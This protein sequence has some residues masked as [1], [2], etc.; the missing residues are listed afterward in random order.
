M[1]GFQ[2]GETY[3]QIKEYVQEHIGLKVSSLYISQ[4]KRNV[5]W[6]LDKTITY[7]RK[8]TPSSHNA[9]LKR[10]KQPWRHCNASE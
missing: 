6:M 4:V 10:K 1:S 8:R 7:P 9:L 5:G 3:P 2:K